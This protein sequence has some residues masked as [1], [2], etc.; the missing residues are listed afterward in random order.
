MR[1]NL[2]SVFAVTFGFCLGTG[3][4]NS[5]GVYSAAA[6]LLLYV[7]FGCA[8]ALYLAKTTGDPRHLD[9]WVNYKVV[10]RPPDGA[11]RAGR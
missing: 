9:G 11:D 5:T 1:L 8:R 2:A 6:V 4:Y 10:D 3:F 7:V